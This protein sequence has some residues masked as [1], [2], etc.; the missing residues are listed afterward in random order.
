MRSLGVLALVAGCGFRTHAAGTVDDAPP[1]GDDAPPV[2]IDA[3]PDATADAAPDAP[4]ADTDGDGVPDANDNCPM[5]ANADQRD[6]DDDGR[7]DVCDLC[8]H[9]PE[10]TDVD[11]D[12]DGVGNACDPRPMTG[13]DT[14][15]LW[16]GFYDANDIT[17]WVQ[18]AQ[19]FSVMNGHLV[20]GRTG[21]GLDY[22]YYPT[23]FQHAYIETLAHYDALANATGSVSPGAVVFTGDAGPVQYYECEAVAT[24]G[25]GKTV[26]AID[27]YPIN[28]S[29]ADQM[30]W[31]GT[32]AVGS[33]IMLKDGVF[34]DKHICRATQGA[35]DVSVT[36]DAG[37]T[38]GA[39]VLGT[40]NATISYDYLFVV[41]IGP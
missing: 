31:T 23:S 1:I 8:P 24:N 32:L 38:V 16:V 40:A 7:G 14:R 30:T 17:G 29:H 33:E 18:N 6:H 20:G 27:A 41:E 22:I 9:I 36:Q 2:V 39:A 34:G 12:S 10:T 21:S 19:T 35:N 4:P 3:S 15:A 37:G 28:Q 13:G 26:Y 11:D 25:G 5:A